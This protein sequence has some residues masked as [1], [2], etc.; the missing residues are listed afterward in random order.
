MP[1]N[2]SKGKALLTCKNLT[3]GIKAIYLVDFKDGGLTP[4]G[5]TSTETGHILNTVA[6]LTAD[7]PTTKAYKFELRHTTNAF[8]QAQTA[9]ED[10]YTTMYAP[11]LTFVLPNLGKEMEYQWKMMAWGRPFLFCQMN[12]GKYFVMGTENG[13]QITGKSDLG[14]TIDAANGYTFTATAKE[15]EPIFWLSAGAITG[16][17]TM[18]STLFVGEDL[19]A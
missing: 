12:N 8:T 11:S 1:C 13:C 9:S 7:S 18:T 15:S 14:G 19:P 6:G 4:S 5:T 10:N 2:I 3:A 17:G 16:L